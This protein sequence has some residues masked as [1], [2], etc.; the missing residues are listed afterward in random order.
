MIRVAETTVKV[1]PTYRSVTEVAPVKFVPVIVTVEPM[2]P[3]MGERPVIVGA[4]VIVVTTNVPTLIAVPP[5]VVTLHF[6]DEAPEGTV[7]VILADELTAYDAATEPSL[8]DVAP[9]K[10]EPL[11]VTDVPTGPLVGVKLEIEGAGGGAVV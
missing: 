6:A 1:V 11:I 3:L 8:T 7:A 2:G 9:V 10:F 4:G 5:A